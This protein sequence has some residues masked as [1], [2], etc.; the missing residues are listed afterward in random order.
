MEPCEELILAVKKSDADSCLYRTGQLMSEKIEVLQLTWIRLVALLGEY[1][2]IPIKKWLDVVRDIRGFIMQEEVEVRL[3]FVITGKLCLLF[4]S[5]GYMSFPKKTL[6]VM[7]GNVLG[8]F[9]ECLLSEKGLSMF[10]GIL[11]KPT[12]EREFCLKIFSG[13][14]LNWKKE[15]KMLLREALEYVCRKDY[16]LSMDF[17]EVLWGFLDV[18]LRGSCEDARVLY[19]CFYKKKERSWRCGLVYAFHNLLGDNLGD[20]TVKELQVIEHVSAISPELWKGFVKTEDKLVYELDKMALLDSFMPAMKK[21][22]GGSDDER[23]WGSGE[24]GWPEESRGV[25]EEKKRV[26][27]KK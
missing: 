16:P 8:L 21:G 4:H 26:I 11:P 12:N 5:E 20:W 13:L 22:G 19:Q 9:D 7:R 27:V 24:G 15:K 2:N 10:G 1:C 17:I 6:N 18:F 14:V 3:G 23:G 25:A